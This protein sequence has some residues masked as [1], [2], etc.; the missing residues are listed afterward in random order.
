VIYSWK[1]KECG[2]QFDRM[3][4]TPTSPDPCPNCGADALRRDWRAESVSVDR[5]RSFGDGKVEVTQVGEGGKRGRT[6]TE[7]VKE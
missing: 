4:R 5:F 1:C 3:N 6:T 7:F 2:Y